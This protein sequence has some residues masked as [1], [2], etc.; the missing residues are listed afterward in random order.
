M[1]RVSINTIAATLSTAMV[2]PD[3]GSIPPPFQTES[4][5]PSN[6]VQTQTLVPIKV[7]IKENQPTHLGAHA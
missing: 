1:D 7:P 4:L 2:Q 5:A 6:F 3:A